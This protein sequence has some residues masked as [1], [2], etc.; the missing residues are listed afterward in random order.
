MCWLFENVPYEEREKIT[1]RR[2]G[3]RGAQGK[4]GRKGEEESN[5]EGT[6]STERDEYFPADGSVDFTSSKNSPRY[7]PLRGNYEIHR[8]QTKKGSTQDLRLTR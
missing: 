5:A 6:E 1:Q 7:N 3:R 4:A 8:R 2:R